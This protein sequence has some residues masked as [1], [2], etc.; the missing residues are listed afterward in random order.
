MPP[1]SGE[2]KGTWFQNLPPS[3]WDLVNRCPRSSRVRHSP[4]GRYSSNLPSLGLCSPPCSRQFCGHR[5]ELRSHLLGL[6]T[7]SCGGGRDQG[8]PLCPGEERAFVSQK[9]DERGLLVLLYQSEKGNVSENWAK[10]GTGAPY[11][12]P[13]PNA[14]S[15]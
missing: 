13:A 14:G 7:K 6:A 2:R 12:F 3:F 4:A 1:F 8:Q 9:S 10:P 15:W 5:A 11:W